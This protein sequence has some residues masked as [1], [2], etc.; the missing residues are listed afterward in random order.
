MDVTSS[1]HWDSVAHEAAGSESEA[2]VAMHEHV[3]G[4]MRSRHD[5][6]LLDLACGTGDLVHRAARAGFESVSG[7]DFSE[8]CLVRASRRVDGR[9]AP[10]W[11]RFVRGDARQL[12]FHDAEFDAVTCVRSWWVL[13]ERR[14][15]AAEVA[16]VLRPAGHLGIQL[17]DHPRSCGLLSL[18]ASLLGK[19]AERARLP[20]GVTGP[21]DLTP[22]SL[23]DE[24][25]AAFE[26][27]ALVRRAVAVDIPDV[28]AYWHHFRALA[29]TA[30]LILGTMEPSSR[31]RL[32]AEL[33]Q[34]LQTLHR[35][36]GQCR[37]SLAWLVCTYVK[38]QS[39]KGEWT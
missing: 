30:F 26:P 27:V 37:L 14:R 12:P 13:P 39:D 31:Q 16:R 29:G 32:D 22:T 28:Q 9:Q 3:I 19:H 25:G 23:S 10:T 1:A 15:I 21:F 36:A 11:M 18:G 20:G 8:Q 34:R 5:G 24:L 33:A 2:V 38:K 7:T 35:R 6:H 4:E 17:W